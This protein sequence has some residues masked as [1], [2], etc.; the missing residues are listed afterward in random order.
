MLKSKPQVL[1]YYNKRFK[2]IMV[3]QFQATNTL[4]FNLLKL[5]N[6]S[7][8]S[9]YAVGDDDHSIYGWRGARS[10]YI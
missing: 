1:E 9:L 2:N 5:L 7:D 4:Q 6:G 8:G 10:K 3:D